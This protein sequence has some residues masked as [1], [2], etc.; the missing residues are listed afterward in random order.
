[1]MVDLSIMTVAEVA[2]VDF[3]RPTLHLLVQNERVMVEELQASLA[4]ASR[5]VSP[6]DQKPAHIHRCIL[7]SDCHIQNSASISCRSPWMSM[8]NIT[9]CLAHGQLHTGL[10]LLNHAYAT[11]VSS[12]PYLCANASGW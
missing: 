3:T 1:M 5:K 9:Q 11:E 2:C 7:I 6:A 4:N 8:P 12:L 10:L